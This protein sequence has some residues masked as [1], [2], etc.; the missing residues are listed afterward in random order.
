VSP[1]SAGRQISEATSLSEHLPVT[2]ARLRA[3]RTSVWPAL[4]LAQLPRNRVQSDVLSRCE[5]WLWQ[6]PKALRLT[7][8]K[9][10]GMA[11]RAMLAI[12][13]DVFND[14]HEQA[15]RDAAVTMRPELGTGMAWL[16][17]YLPLLD[18]AVVMTALDV[19]ANAD[20]LAG[21]ERTAGMLRADKLR[22][23]AENY[24]TG[25]GYA[26]PAS[27]AEADGSGPSQPARRR[28]RRRPTRHGRPAEVHVAVSLDTLRGL[29]ELPGEIPG[30]GP[31]PAT[32]IRELARDAA[33][34]LLVHDPA[35]GHLLD[36]GRSTYRPPG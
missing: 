20:R 1:A 6:Q 22:A 8:A 2:L 27:E 13:P 7:A 29:T 3:E 16:S 26:T 10:A 12:D 5:K 24:L 23:F 15:R 18:A 11:Q 28:R 34:R 31:V 21:D 19:A 32:T 17:A 4:R 36:Y 14:Q 35:N 30:F 25:V 33:V 9:L